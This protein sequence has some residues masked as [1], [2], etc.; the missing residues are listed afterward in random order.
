MPFASPNFVSASCIAPASFALSS[1]PKTVT[2]PA[3]PGP[4]VGGSVV[5]A[6]VSV[7]PDAALVADAASVVPGAPLVADAA[8]VVVAAAC[9]PVVAAELFLLSEP[10]AD[11]ANMNATGSATSLSQGFLMDL[12]LA[13]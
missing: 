7:E 2:D 8:A 11:A 3:L 13:V 4:G 5:A 6:A 9:V 12:P 1:T 10:H